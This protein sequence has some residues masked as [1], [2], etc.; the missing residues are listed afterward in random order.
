MSES[1]QNNLNKH[2]MFS[3]FYQDIHCISF[4]AIFIYVIHYKL[5]VF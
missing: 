1:A 5:K 4:K 3:L 2:F